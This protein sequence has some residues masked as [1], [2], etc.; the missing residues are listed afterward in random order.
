MSEKTKLLV[1]KAVKK[2]LSLLKKNNQVNKEG[3]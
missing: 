3:L 1:E 2:F